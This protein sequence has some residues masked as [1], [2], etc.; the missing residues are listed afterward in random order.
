MAERTEGGN[1]LVPAQDTRI[2]TEQL[3]AR[4]PEL[5]PEL[6][7]LRE[8]QTNAGKALDVAVNDIADTE[9][10]KFRGLWDTKKQEWNPLV[11]KALKEPD[12]SLKQES[13]EMV[14]PMS[15][16]AHRAFKREDPE[17]VKIIDPEKR[18]ED[19]RE[20][21]AALRAVT[22]LMER[23]APRINALDLDRS[24]QK[25]TMARLGTMLQSLESYAG[26]GER[27]IMLS[28]IPE[29]KGYGNLLEINA[30]IEEISQISAH[31][32]LGDVIT[33]YDQQEDVSWDEHSRNLHARDGA[34]VFPILKGLVQFRK[35]MSSDVFGREKSP[36]DVAAL[37]SLQ[38]S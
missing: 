15:V 12:K 24:N 18:T 28:E 37:A 21:V 17:I 16:L 23:Y 19:K 1:P 3:V 5:T 6:R 25:R 14:G 32:T 36:D 30:I 35:A 27:L 10:P 20:Q 4:K 22:A 2:E 11:Y 38:N 34:E 13:E 8:T 9:D 26:F 29:R 7:Q 31:N 33:S